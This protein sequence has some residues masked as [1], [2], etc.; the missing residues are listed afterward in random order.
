[1][2]ISVVKNNMFQSFIS[3]GTLENNLSRLISLLNSVNEKNS[4]KVS[5]YISTIVHTVI[6]VK[7]NF[8][9][10]LQLNKVELHILFSEFNNKTKDII[11]KLNSLVNDLNK[12]KKLADEIHMWHKI[13]EKSEFFLGYLISVKILKTFTPRLMR[14]KNELQIFKM[15]IDSNNKKLK[16]GV[17]R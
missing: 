6:T 7:R 15:L 13:Y 9:R 8:D 12:L 1:M 5:N 10:M 2:S 14:I 16:V 17:R 3:C 11:S 4:Y